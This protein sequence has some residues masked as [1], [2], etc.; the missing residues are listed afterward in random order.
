YVV[1]DSRAGNLVP[2]DTNGATD[3]FVHDRSV[4]STIRVSVTT[5]GEEGDGDSSCPRISRDGQVVAF[6]SLAGRFTGSA[7]DNPGVFVHDRNGT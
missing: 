6:E 7:P 1:F 5:S 2:A 4:A 3:V